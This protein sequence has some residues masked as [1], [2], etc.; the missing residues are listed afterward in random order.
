M[1]SLFKLAILTAVALS[2][3]A[4]PMTSEAAY[5]CK[6]RN[7]HR[8]CWHAAGGPHCWWV[9]GHWKHGVYVPTHKVCR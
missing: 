7:G 2:F 3:S 1:Q 8:V 5:Y 9:H 4:I 6:W